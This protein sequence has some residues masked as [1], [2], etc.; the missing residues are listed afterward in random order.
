M[1]FPGHSTFGTSPFTIQEKNTVL[2]NLK[3]AQQIALSARDSA[4]AIHASTNSQ[5][6]GSGSQTAEKLPHHASEA[7]ICLDQCLNAIEQA[8]SH[9]RS[10]PTAP[11]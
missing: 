2:D 4:L 3:K 9:V 5:T 7:T 11:S 6:S 8:I 1:T 10:L